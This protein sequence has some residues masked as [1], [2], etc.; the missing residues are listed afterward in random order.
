MPTPPF[1]SAR[2]LRDFVPPF[3]RAARLRCPACGGQPVF[4][5]WLKM[6]PSCPSCGI[7]FSRGERGYW[8]GA[9]FVNLVAVETVFCLLLGGLLWA[10]WPDPPWDLVQFLSIVAMVGSPVLIYPWSHTLFLAFDICCR[11]PTPEDFAAPHEAA[12]TVR[13]P[14][15]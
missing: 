1:S 4:V 3:V 11:P 8:L 2:R 6:L 10:T 5:T 13:R 14:S 9:Y 12:R 7:S 15:A